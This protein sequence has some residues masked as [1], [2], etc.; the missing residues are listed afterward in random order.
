MV[1]TEAQEQIALIKYAAIHPILKVYL[2]AIPNGGKRDIVTA[3]RL[4]LQ[5][6]KPG[7]ADLFLAYPID[8]NNIIKCGLFIELKRN[9]KSSKC[10]Q[11]Q[12]V[13]LKNMYDKKYSVAICHGL[14]ETIDC[15]NDYLKYYIEL[16]FHQKYFL[17]KIKNV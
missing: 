3:K 16:E 6:V 7:V 9:I 4:K 11:E 13:F 12:I 10:T 1:P 17:D 2:F 8:Y 5:G 14:N 15:I